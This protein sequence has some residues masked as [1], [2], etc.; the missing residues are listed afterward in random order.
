MFVFKMKLNFSE[1][2]IDSCKPRWKYP[3][4]IPRE[5]TRRLAREIR[6]VFWNS[7]RGIFHENVFNIIFN[8]KYLGNSNR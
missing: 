2:H 4:E 7:S 1:Q 8:Y 6:V 3:R 5:N